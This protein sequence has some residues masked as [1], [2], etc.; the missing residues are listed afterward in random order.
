LHEERTLFVAKPAGYE[1][2]TDRYP[3]L[4]LLD[5]ESHFRVVSGIVDFLAAN[6]RMPKM[7]VVGVASGSIAQRI[8]DL[9]PPTQAETD[10]RFMPGNGGADKFFSFV[11]SELIPFVEKAYRTRPYRMLCGHSLGGLFAI[12]TLMSKPQ[13]F[14]AYVAMDPSLGWNNGG[15]VKQAEAFFAKTTALR[16]DLFM[17]A[18]NAGGKVPAGARRLASILDEKTPVGFRWNFEWMKQETHS[19]VPLRSIQDGL[20]KIFDQWYLTDPMELY[21]N[22]GIEAIH[23]HFRAGGERYVVER[24]T[25]PFTVSMVVAGL[26]WAGRLDESAQVLLHDLKAYPPPWNQCDALARK[27]AE[28]GNNEQAIRFYRL[29]LERNPKNDWARRKLAET[30]EK[31]K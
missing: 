17:T 7:L 6:D 15:V 11:E 22:G 26:M 27:Y 23:R 21:D 14:H 13:L 20:E 31:L 8:R 29:S 16:A 28:S 1:S 2:G 19:S 30:G 10:N 25:S 18:S 4:Y 12:H 5:G 24:T 9:T 3:A